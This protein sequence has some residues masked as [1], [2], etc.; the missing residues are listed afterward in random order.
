MAGQ[1]IA[2]LVATDGYTDPGL[3]QLRAPARGAS[4]LAKLLEDP[5]VGR[6]DYVRAMLN[7]P[8]A[9]IE[10]YVEEVLSDRSPDDLVLLYFSCHGIRND[11]DRLFFATLGTKLQRPHTTAI[12][13]AF[14]HHLLD[15]CQAR[16]KIVLLDCCY[17]GL[18]HRGNA[19]MSAAPV[20]VESALVGRGTFVI[21]ASTALEYA[22]EGD[23]LTLD[24]PHHGSR[25]T[26]SVIEGVSTGLADLNGDGVI[27][28]DELYTFVHDAVVNQS[29]PEQ[30]PTKS[31]QCEGNVPLAYAPR[32]DSAA[33]PSAGAGRADELLLGSLLPPPVDTADRGFICDSWEGSSRLAVPIGRMEAGSGGEPMCLDFSSRE[34]NAAVVGRLGSGK[35][36][37]LRV[38]IM[39]LAL[40]HT[41]HEAEFYLLEGAVNRLGVLRRM[42]HVTMVAAPHEHDA[43]AGILSTVKKAVATRRSLFRERDIDSIEEF[44]ELRASGGL[45]GA[46]GS[47]VFLV[48]DGW[49][50]FHLEDPAFADEIHRLANTGLNYGVHLFASAR[51]WSDFPTD[52]LGL[53]GTRVELALDAPDESLVDASLASSVG[54]GWG[55]AHRRRFRVAVPR[56]EDVADPARARRALS[57]VADR[58]RASWLG[59]RR[60]AADAAPLESSPSFAELF[61][62]ED[63]AALD[64]DEIR[65]SRPTALRLRVPIGVGQ[66]GEPVLLDLKESGSS[67]MGPHG[68]CVGAS[69]SGKS[70]LLRTLVLGLALT[71]SSQ[72]LNFVLADGKGDGAF[73]G[74]RDLPHV[75]AVVAG[76]A[77]DPGMADRLGDAIHGE[78]LRRQ[79]LLRGAGGYASA[80]DYQR[81]RAAGAPL[82]DPLPSLV[83]VVDEFYELLD[84]PQF[85]SL[86]IMI[87]RLGRSLGVHLLLSSQRLEEG[88]LRGLD[89]YLSYR[90]GLRTS[91][92]SE[93]RAVLG[94][95]DALHLP[96]APGSGYLRTGEE[97]TRF[98]AAYVSGACRTDG[99]A[100]LD[101]D[102]A[103][104]LLDVVVRQLAGRGPVAHPIWLPP[105]DASPSVA[106]LLPALATSPE[107]GLHPAEYGERG[108]RLVVPVAIVDNPL[109][110][111][112][113]VMELD[114]SGHMGHGLVVGRPQSGK[115]TL[116]RAVV[117][118]FALTHTP[119]EVQ[120]YCLDF[121]GGGMSQLAGLP[122]VGSVASRL[123]G[124]KVRRTVAEI[125]IFLDAREEL[126]RT[127]GIDS[128]A[129][130]RTRLAAGHLEEQRWGDVFLVVDGWSSFKTEYELLDPMIMDI[131]ERGPGLG[132]HLLISASRHMEVRPALRSHLL[133]RIELRLGD[134]AESEID[135]EEAENVPMGAPGRGLTPQKLHF[136][137]ALPRLADS[138]GRDTLGEETQR[139]AATVR[140]HWPGPA[141]PPVRMLPDLLGADELPKAGAFPGRGVPIGVD[142]ATLT[143]V[144]VDFETDPLLLV[145]GESESGKSSLLRLLARQI[146]ARHTADQAMLVV[147]DY[148]RSL[149]GDVP[150]SY[151]L[152]YCTSGAQL[153][154]VLGELAES[155]AQRMPS[156]HTT[157]EQLRDRSWYHGRD[158]YVLV[159]DY[160]L[161]STGANPLA[162]LSD[163]L[164]FARDLGLRVVLAR[165]SVG[166]SR[167]SY[168]PFLSRMKEAGAQGLVLSGDASEGNLIG[169]VRPSRQ[170]P[171]RGTLVTRRHSLRQIQLAY[172]PL[173]MS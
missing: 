29:G 22:Y 166:A 88:R 163:H 64:L 140:S 16:S 21:T 111:R 123:E 72:T 11:K 77:D 55:L 30:T 3:N 133:T 136:L 105:L 113:D 171:G 63:P 151:L 147:A 48:V 33:R 85:N 25:F 150:K 28:P 66:G 70:E 129:A 1:R 158:A 10:S 52:L 9:E 114:F 68:L 62:V 39:S 76:F 109:E 142:E 132:V 90:I 106:Q 87:G 117:A 61:G 38:M 131:A 161:L 75:S 118:A 23:Q 162:P 42:P 8:K 127:E 121:G 12:P 130:F 4:E 101:D 144:F 51:R 115:S 107:R 97:T 152:K 96:P 37:L 119:A 54:V 102:G 139:L 14:L 92:G 156:E 5:M 45:Q 41:P 35:T 94:V 100:G 128:V 67:G 98:R 159:D 138:D 69:G 120:F 15:E 173:H 26:A 145:F 20:D 103:D 19:P 160:E 44:R 17:S 27:T 65:Q 34:G 137:A 110:Q 40:T 125:A 146:T 99:A 172:Q 149:L 164:P 58:I 43:V 31:G 95:P 89:T 2:L 112:R 154:A 57:D 71:H 155:L 46:A 83:F 122:H 18:F 6:F 81:A 135:R 47:D 84:R 79:N 80:H 126:F 82:E 116:L 148:R 134:P 167:A 56:I 169:P 168:E 36:T 165:S 124:E 86:L 157:P 153:K 93:S 7:R 73:D 108:R 13:A 91:S 53:L 78:L 50:D 59:L 104:T 49:L 32:R 170:P 60:E 74:L 24:N 141:A 143:P